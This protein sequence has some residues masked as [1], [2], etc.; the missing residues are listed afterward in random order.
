MKKELT[1]NEALEYVK[2]YGI[3]LF[4]TT[5]KLV[6]V[7]TH[8][9]LFFGLNENHGISTR[10]KHTENKNIKFNYKFDYCC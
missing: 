1:F 9:K 2:N 5:G 6:D 3:T 4:E 8:T 7:P 10:D